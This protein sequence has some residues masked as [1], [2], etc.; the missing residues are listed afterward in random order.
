M[1]AGGG[2]I[3]SVA[4]R[5]SPAKQQRMNHQH[6][7]AR[8]SAACRTEPAYPVARTIAGRGPEG[9]WRSVTPSS[10]LGDPQKRAKE[11]DRGERER[12]KE[13]RERECLGTLFI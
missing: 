2:G 13:K 6:P 10:V 9:R 7:I 8:T 4:R 3:D 1:I 12:K 5:P 11:G